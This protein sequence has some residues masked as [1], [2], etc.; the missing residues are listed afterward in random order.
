MARPD[1][2]TGRHD[3]AHPERARVVAARPPASA[4]EGVHA[5]AG[6]DSVADDRDVA[7]HGAVHDPAAPH[8]KP[9]AGHG[10]L[11][12]TTVR[13]RGRRRAASVEEQQSYQDFVRSLH[14]KIEHKL[15]S[16]VEESVQVEIA[17]LMRL[18]ATMDWK[19]IENN[20]VYFEMA[21]DLLSQA[22]PNLIVVRSLRFDLAEIKDRSAGGLSR[23]LTRICGDTPLHAVL[24]GLCAVMVISFLIVLLI[25]ALHRA[26][27]SYA[28]VV[29][30]DF[31]LL[32]VIRDFPANHIILIVHAAFIGSLVSILVR[33]RDFLSIA[34]F[35]SLLIFVTIVTKPFVSVMFAILA[36]VMMKSGV[37]SFMSID[38]DGPQGAYLAWGLGFLCGF[39]ERL[40]QDLVSRAG[41]AFGGD[42]NARLTGKAA[43]PPAG[44]G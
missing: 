23:S 34:A 40:A 12:D 42:S 33:I 22:Q 32:G 26:A 38:L 31:P 20:R 29:D 19:T 6:S 21:F 36:F 24:S 39:S 37:I 43:A 10:H 11:A 27:I 1:P 17:N 35:S 44:P 16:R 8:H 41:S 13:S 18:L 15:S 4:N 9:A 28:H 2:D 30:T 5:L 14:A 7:H 3:P 25:F